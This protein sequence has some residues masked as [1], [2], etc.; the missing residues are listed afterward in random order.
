MRRA[1]TR[2]WADGLSAERAQVQLAVLVQAHGAV[3]GRQQGF[4]VV[5]VPGHLPVDRAQALG[6]SCRHPG[7]P[8]HLVFSAWPHLGAYQ[9]GGGVRVTPS[10]TPDDYGWPS[11]R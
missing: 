10:T 6:E 5:E 4:Q 2:L 1:G 3:A 7:E 8:E 11:G 9:V